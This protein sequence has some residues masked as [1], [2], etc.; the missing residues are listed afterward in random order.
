MITVTMKCGESVFQWSTTVYEYIF[1]W[2]CP[3]RTDPE[4]YLVPSSNYGK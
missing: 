3:A 1:G 2:H 4:G